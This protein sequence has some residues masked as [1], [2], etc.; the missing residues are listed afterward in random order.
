[1]VLFLIGSIRF[2]GVGVLMVVERA[3]FDRVGILFLVGHVRFLGVGVSV[4]IDDNYFYK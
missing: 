2:F 1:M 3:F 4:G